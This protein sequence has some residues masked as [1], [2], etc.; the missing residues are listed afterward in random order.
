MYDPLRG[1]P[2]KLRCPF[3]AL[4]R[5]VQVRDVRVSADALPAVDLVH[6]IEGGTRAHQRVVL[7]VA[8]RGIV[9]SV[10]ISAESACEAEPPSR[11]ETHLK[12]FT[13]DKP[14]H[15]LGLHQPSELANNDGLPTA[16]KVLPSF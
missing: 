9:N 8:V 4:V 12:I 6:D 1:T 14:Y 10:G 5:G 3:T 7:A 16:H 2:H 15:A 11:R 13:E